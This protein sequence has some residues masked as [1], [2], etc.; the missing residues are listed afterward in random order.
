[1]VSIGTVVGG[2]LMIK[3]VKY[4]S[5]KVIQF[6][7]FLALFVIFIVTGSAWTTLLDNS[8]SGLII[9]YA[10][11]H[12]AFNLGPNV[13]TFIIPA[14]IFP[15]RYRCTCHGIAAASGKL[16][17]WV[18]QIFIAYAFQSGSANDGGSLKWEE[19][20]DFGH[21]LQVMSAFMLA[22]AITTYFLVPETRDHDNK[23]RTLEV[24]A[25]GKKVIDELNRQRKKED[26]EE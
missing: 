19:R 23:S 4:V 16:G 17:S 24:L 1:M 9:L 22:G 10:L 21:V 2:L 20:R 3:I 26:E 14:E 13:T 6:W 25:C 7:G 15:T 5:P 12:I 8:R 18:V 11:S